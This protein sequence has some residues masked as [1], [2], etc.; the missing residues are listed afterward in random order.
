MPYTYSLGARSRD[1]LN[2]VCTYKVSNKCQLLLL[3]FSIMIAISKEL[4]N[5]LYTV[6]SYVLLLFFNCI[7]YLPGYL[8]LDFNHPSPEIP[9]WQAFCEKYLSC[10]E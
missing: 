4:F 6:Y 3:P 7:C 5:H 9:D 1:N 10:S 8:V 2:S